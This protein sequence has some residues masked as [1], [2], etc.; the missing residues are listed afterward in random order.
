VA[1]VM[2]GAAPG[3]E[4]E[5]EIVLVAHGH[6]AEAIGAVLGQEVALHKG[7]ALDVK[8]VVAVVAHVA[9]IVAIAVRMIA[10]VLLSRRWYRPTS[11]SNFFQNQVV[12]RALAAR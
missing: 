6:P 4:A 5:A 10:I 1:I 2:T 8:V 9:V 7:V 12:P 11:E 3:P